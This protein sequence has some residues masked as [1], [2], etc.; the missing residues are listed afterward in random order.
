MVA[1]WVHDMGDFK[2]VTVTSSGDDPD[3][4]AEKWWGLGRLIWSREVAGTN[5]GKALQKAIIDSGE[6][7]NPSDFIPDTKL[8]G[9]TCYAGEVDFNS[10][11][12]ETTEEP[13]RYHVYLM[14]VDD[15][16]YKCGY[17]VGEPPIETEWAFAVSSK[18]VAAEFTKF[19]HYTLS[20]RR[21]IRDGKKS[22]IPLYDISREY[23]IEQYKAWVSEGKPSKKESLIIDFVDL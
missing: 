7:C 1:V 6:V 14:E 19:V 11:N 2:K 9:K 10:L 22:F 13:S 17:T 18:D 15:E 8:T 5:E 12:W 21:A 3:A 23:C 4:Y 16:Y 20:K